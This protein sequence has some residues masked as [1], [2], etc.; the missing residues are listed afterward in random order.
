MIDAVRQWLTSIILTSF[1]LSLLQ[2]LLPEGSLRKAGA[3]TG[4]LV[5]LTAIVRPLARLEPDWPDWNLSAYER[6]ITARMDELNAG[7]EDAFAAQVAERTAAAIGAY[8]PG[9]SAR[10]TVRVRD[11]VPLPWAV[12]LSGTP[13][14]DLSAWLATAL[15]IPPERQF[16][17]DSAP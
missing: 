6:A 3:F 5:L 16:W 10:V 15:D 2:L 1:L 4:S 14:A 8:A 12:T 9:V 7:Q 13:D 17:T 11:G